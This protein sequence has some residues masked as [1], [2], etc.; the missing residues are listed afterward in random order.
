MFGVSIEKKYVEKLENDCLQWVLENKDTT[1]ERYS[2]IIDTQGI[3]FITID[4]DFY[5]VIS[6]DD[7]PNV[8]FH[9]DISDFLTLENF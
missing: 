8:D 9:T 7:Y 4:E 5:N 3:F 2:Q 1:G 6:I